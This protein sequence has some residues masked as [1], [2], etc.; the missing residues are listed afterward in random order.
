MKK[1]LS[2]L[3]II[4]LF[5]C[6]CN[7]NK[8][9]KNFQISSLKFNDDY[10]HIVGKIKNLTDKAYNI[11]IFFELKSG[12]LVESNTCY[13]TIK[14][15]ETKNIECLIYNIDD[16]YSFEIENVEFKEFSIPKLKEGEISEETFKYYFEEIYNTHTLNFV[17]FSTMFDNF[18]YPYINKINYENNKIEIKTDLKENEKS[19]YFTTTYNTENNE[20]ESLSGII[21][22]ASDSLLNEI[23]IQISL[24]NS[25]RDKY[26]MEINNIKFYKA[27]LNNDIEY[28]RCWVVDNWCITPIDEYGFFYIDEYK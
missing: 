11:E 16:T 9:E 12:T 19:I 21:Y 26:T 1:K 7:E 17:G 10:D 22:N 6:G 23:A 5:L 27:L 24:M 3:I 20:L 25:I 14:P 2:F 18:N 4:C 28:G 8:W 13:A 15:N